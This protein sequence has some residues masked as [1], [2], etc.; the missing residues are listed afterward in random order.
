[1]SDSTSTYPPRQKRSEETLASLL[2]A[3]IRVLDEDGLDG[4]T[5]PRIAALA[6][7]APA[8]VY[9]RFVN[10]DA[11]IRAALLSMLANSRSERLDVAAGETL[12]ET[13]RRLMTLLFRQ[14]RQHPR[15]LRALSRFLDADGDAA[16]VAEARAMLACNLTLLAEP[17]LVHRDQIHHADPQAALRFALLQALTSIES[18][19]LEPFSLWHM[20]MD[21]ADEELAKRFADAFVAYLARR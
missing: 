4:A 10:K 13:A 2:A 11:L 21:E 5:I 20:T 9:R 3:T 8:S 1:M 16:F 6:G 12:P 18:I 7:V 15:L 17:L 14:Y 19:A